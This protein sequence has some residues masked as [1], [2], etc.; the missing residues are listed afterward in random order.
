M[1]DI[2][3]KKVLMSCIQLVGMHLDYQQKM[4]QLSE[5]PIQELGPMKILKYKKHRCADTP[6]PLIGIEY[7]THVT[8]SITNGT[9][10]Y[11]LR[12]LKRVWRIEKIVQLIGAQIAKLYWQMSR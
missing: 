8:L 1:L 10:G 4:L 12:C 2:G 7:F 5:M 11:F 9:N 3:F 6:A